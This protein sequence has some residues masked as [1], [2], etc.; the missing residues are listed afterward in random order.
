MAAEVRVVGRTGSLAGG[1]DRRTHSLR[2]PLLAWSTK[3]TTPDIAGRVEPR[4]HANVGAGPSS[5]PQ[6]HDTAR[7]CP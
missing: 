2:Q 7:R 4:S 1:Y 5:D 3:C 6:E